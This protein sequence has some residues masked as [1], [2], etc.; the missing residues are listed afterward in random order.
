LPVTSVASAPKAT[1]DGGASAHSGHKEAFG[2][3]DFVAIRAVGLHGGDTVHN[4]ALLC[5]SAIIQALT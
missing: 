4:Y 2:D 5:L 3:F 1:T